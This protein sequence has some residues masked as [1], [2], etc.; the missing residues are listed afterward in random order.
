[1]SASI[2]DVIL[3]DNIKLKSDYL[4]LWQLWKNTLHLSLIQYLFC[5]YGKNRFYLWTSF[6]SKV[7]DW[8]AACDVD[9][10][11]EVSFEEFKFSLMGNLMVEIW[12][13]GVYL[14]YRTTFQ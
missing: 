8:L 5:L 7:E 4:I 3:N 10:D 2:A 14:I 13:D 9:N 12:N 6:I 11:G 1:M